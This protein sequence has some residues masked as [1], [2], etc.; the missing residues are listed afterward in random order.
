MKNISKIRWIL[1][2][3]LILTLVLAIALAGCS[4]KSQAPAKGDQKQQDSKSVEVKFPTKP[5]Q[6]LCHS[7]AG[8]PVDVMARQLAKY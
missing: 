6:I 1:V 8:S 4:G 5:I 7:A 2:W 3:G